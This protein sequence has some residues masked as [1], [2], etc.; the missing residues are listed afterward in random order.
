[1]PVPSHSGSR[2]PEPRRPA[3]RPGSEASTHGEPPAAPQQDNTPER[4]FGLSAALWSLGILVALV[5]VVGTGI[6]LSAAINAY[7]RAEKRANANNQVALTRIAI[8]R[9]DQQTRVADAQLGAAQADAQARYDE[10]VGIRRAED[11]IAGK[12]T[13]QYLQYLAIQAQKAVAT[14]GRNNTLIYLPSGS[15]GVPLVQDPQNTNRLNATP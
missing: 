1:M 10:A 2:L 5:I 4:P 8:R 7:S 6:G 15:G 12:L 13:P 11:A 3:R 9:S 14:S